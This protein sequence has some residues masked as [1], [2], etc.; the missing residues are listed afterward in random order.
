M[1]T[2]ILSFLKRERDCY[3]NVILQTFQAAQR[4]S[5]FLSFSGQKDVETLKN[6]SKSL[7]QT[8]RSGERM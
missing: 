6:R 5:S 7:M 4:S 2:V 3:V 1:N 8:V